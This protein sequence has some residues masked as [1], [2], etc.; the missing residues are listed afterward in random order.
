MLLPMTDAHPPL[1]E[2]L[3]ARNA[4]RA[5]S[6][7]EHTSAAAVGAADKRGGSGGEAAEPPPE[8]PQPPPPPV[9]GDPQGDEGSYSPATAAATWSCCCCPGGSLVAS[10]CPYTAPTPHWHTPS[11]SV[12]YLTPLNSIS[13]GF[14]IPNKT[15][16]S[17]IL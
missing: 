1:T 5:A 6:E 2:R 15:R 14:P 3:V 4:T 9:L 8:A 12:C 11:F 7:G 16:L 10:G 17:L 13:N